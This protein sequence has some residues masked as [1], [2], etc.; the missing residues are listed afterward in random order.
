L[1]DPKKPVQTRDGH[2]ARIVATDVKN[3]AYP[4]LGVIE[5]DGGET[6]G[7]Y[8]Y[9]KEGLLFDTCV[10]KNRIDPR[11]LVNI[12]TKKCGWINVYYGGYFPKHSAPIYKTKKDAADNASSIS[13]IAQVFIE[14]EEL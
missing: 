1:F 13:N 6:E 12:P 8:C 10:Y 3:E 14:W 11:D 5:H 4:V 2:K 7:V 9:T